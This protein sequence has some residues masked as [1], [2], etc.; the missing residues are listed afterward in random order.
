MPAKVLHFRS[1][2]ALPLDSLKAEQARIQRELGQA[3]TLIAQHQQDYQALEIVGV[4]LKPGYV[5]LLDDELVA[6]L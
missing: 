2:D 6:E 1:A 5:T 3:R 4:D